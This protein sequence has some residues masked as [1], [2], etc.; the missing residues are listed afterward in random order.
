ME[1]NTI[2]GKQVRYV[3]RQNR[4]NLR[5]ADDAIRRIIDNLQ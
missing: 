4:I 3:L 1:K 5:H 2:S